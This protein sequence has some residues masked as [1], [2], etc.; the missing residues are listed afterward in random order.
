MK[1]ILIISVLAL[2]IG[3]IVVAAPVKRSLGDNEIVRLQ[4]QL[5]IANF[6]NALELSDV[7]LKAIYDLAVATRENLEN[8]QERIKG[9]LEESLEKAIAGEKVTPLQ[10]AD[11][12]KR[13]QEIVKEYVAGLKTIITVDQSEKLARYLRAKITEKLPAA[14]ERVEAL[15]ERLME[16]LPQ[17]EERLK[18][19]LKSLPPQALER[20]KNS[21]AL[22]RVQDTREKVVTREL[23]SDSKVTTRSVRVS[24]DIQRLSLVLLSDA[25]LEVMEK[26]LEQ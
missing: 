20:L 1:K 2:V 10:R 24:V 14:N 5:Q 21:N 8:L 26:M 16:N 18:E 7:Q 22:E 6:L 4:H 25:A 23:E 15:K 17:V 11:I 12:V 19:R 3:V 13:V 9:T